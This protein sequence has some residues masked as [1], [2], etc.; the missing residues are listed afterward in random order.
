MAQRLAQYKESGGY[1]AYERWANTYDAN[2]MKA[3][4]ANVRVDEFF[5]TKG[6][7]CPPVCREVSIQI[8]GKTRRLD[9]ADN[10]PGVQYGVEFK[11]YETGKVY[12]SADIRAEIELDR[13]LVKNDWQIEWVFKD[14]ELS[15]PLEQLLNEAGIKITK[16]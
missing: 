4:L 13:L 8:G 12:A 1:W 5:T 10:R 14:C 6:Y 11:S 16:L 3:R 2:M 9:I 15:E 7:N